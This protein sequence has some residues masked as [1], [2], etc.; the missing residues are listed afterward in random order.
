MTNASL[1]KHPLWGAFAVIVPAAILATAVA[2]GPSF[3]G[4]FLTHKQAVKTF[5]K[6]K[7][8][9]SIYL[10]TK[11]AKEEYATKS[12]LTPTP[13]SRI[14]QSTVDFGP[15]YST[16]PFDIPGARLPFKVGS[17]T[18]NVV[19]T[20]SGQ[21]TC[22]DDKTG[23]G[24]P[25]QILLDGAPTGAGKV[26][27]MTSTSGSSQPKESVHTVVNSTIVTPGQHVVSV[28]YAGNATDPSLGFKVFDYNLVVE[29]YPG[30]DIPEP[31]E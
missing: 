2:V 9:A 15:I 10:P 4:S 16:T 26:N 11:T 13:F 8:A 29:A 12:E 17:T 20:Y 28:R 21:A 22:V 1:R 6:K 3:A 18:N 19:I 30:P 31:I 5:V 14:V 25:I 24:C 7:E 27:F 23:V